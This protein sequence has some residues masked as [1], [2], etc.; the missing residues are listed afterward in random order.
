MDV[1]IFI[2]VAYLC[3]KVGF[4][5]EPAISRKFSLRTRK[6]LKSEFIKVDFLVSRCNERSESFNSDGVTEYAECDSVAHVNSD[7]SAENYLKEVLG[8]PQYYVRGKIAFSSL[9]FFDKKDFGK[10][11]AI[12]SISVSQHVARC[13]IFCNNRAFRN[14]L[15]EITKGKSIT[16][17]LAGISPKKPKKGEWLEIAV[18][19]FELRREGELAGPHWFREKFHKNLSSASSDE[20]ARLNDCSR[21]VGETHLRDF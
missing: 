7:E 12:G 19:S 3:V 15:E 13:H 21:F 11:G 9:E 14:V 16:L 5:I 20:R 6:V 4:I 10:N 1:A 18:H 2:L 8:L 17:S